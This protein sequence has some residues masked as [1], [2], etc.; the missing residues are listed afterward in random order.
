MA[1]GTL[2]IDLGSSSTL[3][4]WQAAAGEPSQLLHLTTISRSSTDPVIPSLVSPSAS[5]PLLGQ[6]VLDAG[7][8]ADAARDFKAQLSQAAP[9]AGARQAAEALLDGI[10][11]RLP[12]TICPERLVMT[13]PVHG[14]LHYRQWLQHW[15]EQQDVDEVALVDEPTAAALG[16]GLPPGSL[17]LVLDMGAGTTDLSL[18]RLEG[19]QGRAMPMAQLLRF[20]G[21]SVP[22]SQR[23]PRTAKVIGKAGA[24]VG[25][26]SIDR[27]WA[28]A[29]G[30]P[31]SLPA[32]WL[33]AAEQLKC[34]LSQLERAQVVLQMGGRTQALQGTRAQ[35]EG[36]LEQHGLPELMQD[37]L[38]QVEAAA[39]RGGESL[40]RVDAV[41]AVGGGSE[42]PWLQQWLKQHLPGRTLAVSQPLAAVVQGALAMTPALQVMDVLQSGVS[43]RCWDQRLGQ[44]RWHPLFWPGQA[45]PT[46]QPLELVL[47]SQGEQPCLELQ[48]GTPQP[49]SRSEVVFVDGMPTLR[50]AQ[51]GDPQVNLWAGGAAELAL[52]PPIKD[53]EDRLALRFGIDQQRQLW[54]EGEDLATKELLPR[55]IL[56]IVE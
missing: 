51:A 23:G 33:D 56:G 39:R 55:R 37:L 44:Q 5:R 13:A 52:K 9:P 10:W 3:V 54:M 14:F 32:G 46:P 29:L 25:G 20:G 21:R 40:E 12:E 47:A 19:G 18:V 48:L 41:M 2:A 34:Q 38:D 50:A 31:E 24:T 8:E 49:V 45:W 42:L 27:W 35:L 36:V 22:Q 7:L 1:Q 6:Q 16:A 26:R 15:A 28:A 53:G 43:L 17:V 4:G 30:A 11:A